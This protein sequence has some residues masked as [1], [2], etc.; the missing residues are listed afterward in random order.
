[1]SFDP[2]DLI[3]IEYRSL[4]AI[5]SPIEKSGILK[6]I[7]EKYAEMED[8]Y[9][10]LFL[11]LKDYLT[12]FQ[13]EDISSLAFIMFGQISLDLTKEKDISNMAAVL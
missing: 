7:R 8:K 3:P 2:T 6:I 5:I 11:G 9:E 10:A 12:K 13:G 4:F 1:M